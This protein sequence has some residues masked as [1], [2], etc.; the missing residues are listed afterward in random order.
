MSPTRL[1]TAEDRLQRL[2]V[3]LPWLMEVGEAPLADVAR[4]FDMTEADV[5]KNLELVAM[6]GLPPFVDEMVD[7]FVDEGIVYVGVPRLFT[8][9]L[10]LTSPEAFALLAAG[11]AA[12]ELPGADRA[13]PLGRGLGKLENALDQVGLQIGD[14]DRRRRVRPRPAAVDRRP[15]RTHRDRAPKSR[16]TTTRP[17]VT[18]SSTR[19]IVP[20]HV[21]VDGGRWYVLADD[22]RSGAR[23]TFRVDRIEELSPD[24]TACSDRGVRGRTVGLLR[25]CRCSP[26]RAPAGARGAVD[27]RGV[28]GRLGAA[29]RRSPA[30]W[31][32]V[33]L[34]VT[35][36]RWLSRLLIR[37]GPAVVAVEPS[38]AAAEAADAGPAGARR[39]RADRRSALRSSGRSVERLQPVDL[40]DVEGGEEVRQDGRRGRRV[41]ER[42]VGFVE[43]DAVELAEVAQA[44]RPLSVGVEPARHAQ[45]AQ[46]PLEAAP[47]RVVGRPAACGPAQEAA[48]EVGVV[49]REDG[50][51]EALAELGEHVVER[52]AHP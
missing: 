45:R 36:D 29:A 12:M 14:V 44:V 7:V 24:R 11:R 10:R 19:T 46:R 3:M 38:T 23:R 37:L 47:D 4:R 25:R 1:R 17:I 39:L 18:R 41:G 52:A 31:V 35:S 49:G 6:C 42:V 16:S 21:F 13:G 26:R 30:G 51:V 50:A 27:R 9:P 33:R 22:A 43:G 2:L 34:P 40:V 48:V 28:S 5:E 15:R 8:R 20:R 32:E